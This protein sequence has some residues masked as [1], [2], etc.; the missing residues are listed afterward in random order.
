M[1]RLPAVSQKYSM[2]LY[3]SSVPLPQLALSHIYN[4]HT[5]HTHT[6]LDDKELLLFL[7]KSFVFLQMLCFIIFFPIHFIS[8][9]CYCWFCDHYWSDL[10]LA[11]NPVNTGNDWWL[12]LLDRY[13]KNVI[14]LIEYVVNLKFHYF[15]YPGW[16][17]WHSYW[18]IPTKMHRK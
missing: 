13:E 1:V 6:V 10:A 12:I 16:I 18:E 4:L 8:A 11:V 5:H 9:S 2:I 14:S 15:S 3:L 17:K 7:R